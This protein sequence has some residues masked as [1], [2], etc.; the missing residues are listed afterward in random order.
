M[1]AQFYDSSATSIHPFLANL[2]IEIFIPP[3]VL[4]LLETKK[5]FLDNLLD[6]PMEIYDFDLWFDSDRAF[7]LSFVY[8]NV[9]LS[10]LNNLILQP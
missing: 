6:I 5:A 10:D 4:F 8:F 2:I 7:V 9:I 3:V 1:R